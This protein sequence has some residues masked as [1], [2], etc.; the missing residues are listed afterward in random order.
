V[1]DKLLDIYEFCVPATWQKCFL[2]HGFD[3]LQH[4]K[5]EFL[6]FCEQIETTV[7]IFEEYHGAKH[8][9]NPN[10]C[11]KAKEGKSALANRS[12]GYTRNQNNN[13]SMK[14]CKLH[15]QQQSHG[16]EDCKVL[17]D[18][19]NK[20]KATWKTQP[21]QYQ[22]KHYSA[23]YNKQLSFQKSGEHDNKK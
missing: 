11:Y 12:S 23:N 15:C 16:T 17:L 20:I 10:D 6:E 13:K 2:L 4:T 7:D 14:F 3:P 21:Q 8:K 22:K 9:A 18:Q 5:Y 19:A 1:E